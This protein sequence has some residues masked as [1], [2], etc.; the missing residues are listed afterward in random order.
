MVF[1]EPHSP[2]AGTQVP[3]GT[4]EPGESLEAAVLREAY[5][6]TGLEGLRLVRALGVQLH[7]R[8]SGRVHR[9]HYFHLVCEADAVQSV[10]EHYEEHPHSG[11]E[12]ILYRLRWADLREPPALHAELDGALR[13]LRLG[14][15]RPHRHVRD[16]DG[17]RGSMRRH[18]SRALILDQQ[19]R[20]LL[21]QARLDGRELWV[22]PGGGV[23]GDETYCAALIRELAE[24]VGQ[25]IDVGPIVW[26]RR[27][28]AGDVGSVGAKGEFTELFFHARARETAYRPI[29]ADHYVVG[30]KWWSLEELAGSSA[31]FAPRGLPALPPAVIP[32]AATGPLDIGL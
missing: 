28:S 30:H 6:E 24:E 31:L 17:R 15:T 27:Y 22:T 25:P 8:P 20:V 26:V 10:W 18:A 12:P 29:K 1:E 23:E 14:L 16:V 9:R 19:S 4:V 5:E 3:G 11:S 21:L 32:G 2:S 13:Q 7:R